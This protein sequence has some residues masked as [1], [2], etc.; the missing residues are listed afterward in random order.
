MLF[1]NILQTRDQG[2]PASFSF[3]LYSK[4]ESI[5]NSVESIYSSVIGLVGC[6]GVAEIGV[7]N[8]GEKRIEL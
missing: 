4:Y 5:I 8:I 6:T 7:L 3:L 1:F 2:F